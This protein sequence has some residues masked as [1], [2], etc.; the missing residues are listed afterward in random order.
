MR[1]VLGATGIALAALGILFGGPVADASTVTLSIVINSAASTSVTCTPASG[2]VAPLAAGTEL[3]PITVVPSGWSGTL[4]LSGAN[5]SEFAISSGT[6]GEE[7]VVG[8]TALS[9][10]TYS[11][12]ITATP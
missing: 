4:A 1:K 2:L 5:A 7:L 8:S 6:S 9:A 3:C 12:T 11:V 10:G